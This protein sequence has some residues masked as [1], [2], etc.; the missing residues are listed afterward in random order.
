[1]HEDGQ[2]LFRCYGLAGIRRTIVACAHRLG[3]VDGPLGGE[4]RKAAEDDLL[5]CVE[6]SV[7]S[8]EERF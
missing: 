7:T 3:G 2:H 5:A 8:V 1:M 4:D 6:Q